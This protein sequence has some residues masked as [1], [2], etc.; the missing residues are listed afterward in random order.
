LV[1]TENIKVLREACAEVTGREMGVR[2]VVK[3]SEAEAPPTSR[4]DEERIERQ[5]LRETAENSPIVQEMLRTFRGEIVDVR[6][7]DK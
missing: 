5:R 6:R 2:I 7:A 3:D 1:K 4:E